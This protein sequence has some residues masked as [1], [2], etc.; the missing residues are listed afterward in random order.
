MTH[1]TPSFAIKNIEWLIFDKRSFVFYVTLTDIF[2]ILRRV[3]GSKVLQT[4]NTFLVTA[5]S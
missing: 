1:L 3:S 5:Y 4:A 2:K